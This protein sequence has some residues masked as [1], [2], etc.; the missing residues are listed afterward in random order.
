[1]QACACIYYV[2]CI[3]VRNR[4]SAVQTADGRWQAADARHSQTDRCLT[5][6][7]LQVWY[8]DTYKVRKTQPLYFRTDF[9]ESCQAGCHL[10]Q[11]ASATP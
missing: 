8:G 7:C 10:P 1:M 2:Q 11:Y 6:H 5:M 9:P 4:V 3:L